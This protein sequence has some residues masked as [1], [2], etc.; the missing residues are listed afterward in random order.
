MIADKE[1]N[2]VAH[3]RRHMLGSRLARTDNAT[4]K[5]YK[6]FKESVREYIYE[7]EAV[8]E[9]SYPVIIGNEV[10]G[11]ATI[12]Y[13]LSTMNTVID[14]RL[15]NLKKYIYMITA[16]MLAAGIAGAFIV[17][18][19]LTKPLKR[20]KAKMLDIQTGNLNVE[21][22]NPR[23]VACWKRLNCKKTDCPSYGKLRCWATAGTF[24]RDKVQGQFAQKIGDCR[25]CVVYKESCGDEINEFVEVFNQMVKDLKYNLQEL[26]KANS[27]KARMERLSALGEMATTVAHEI[28]NPLNAIKIA[29]SYLKNNFHG[30]ILTEFLSIVEEE[31][32]RLND[33]S[34]NFLGFSKP[35][36]INLKTCD[37]NA[38]VEST[39]NLIRQEAAEK[40]IEIVALLDRGLPLAPCDYSRIKQALLNLLLN[41]LEASKAGDTVEITT[42]NEGPFISIIVE[43]TGQGISSEDMENI[44]KPFFTTKTRGSGL[45]LA[46][47]DRIVK[48]HGGDIEVDSEVGKGTKF[49]IKLKVYEYAKA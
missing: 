22:E 5:D 35:E 39:V 43:D 20:L 49:T 42:W 34:S 41:A 29:T 28:K 25:K 44:F 18:N 13:S 1:G 36:P 37:I 46:I 9:F 23:L 21:V 11:V 48:E 16:I 2:I 8:K 33:I 6:F 27:E 19:I 40:N 47:I 10:L 3:T 38:L 32:S 24:C 30:A 7:N 15:K 31:V 17:S 14:D 12:A 4:A 45:G 26:E